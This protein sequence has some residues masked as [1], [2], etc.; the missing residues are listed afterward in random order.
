MKD[1]R[2]LRATAERVHPRLG[3]YRIGSRVT[4]GTPDTF[5]LVALRLEGDGDVFPI[6]VS[7]GCV[8]GRDTQFGILERDDLEDIAPAQDDP[9]KADAARAWA[10]RDRES[11]TGY[12][13]DAV[14]FDIP[15]SIDQLWRFLLF[16]EADREWRIAERAQREAAS[17]RASAVAQVAWTDGSQSSAARILGLNQSTVS[18]AVAASTSEA[19]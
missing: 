17:R 5:T 16:C 10:S 9:E 14:L 8:T 3:E 6:Y 4:A 12:G 19:P 2:L 13:H 7:D 1:P 15:A 18:R 11:I